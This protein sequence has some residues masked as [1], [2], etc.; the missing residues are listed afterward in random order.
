MKRLFLLMLST[1][2]KKIQKCST[3]LTMNSLSSTCII[4]MDSVKASLP[5]R[6]LNKW[7]EIL[8]SSSQDLLS[9]DLESMSNI[10]METDSHNGTTSS[11]PS[12]E[13]S[14]SKCTVFH[15]SVMTFVDSTT[16]LGLNSVQDGCNLDL[17]IHSLV[18]TT[19]TSPSHK[20]HTLSQLTSTF[21]PHQS[22]H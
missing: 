20:S 8:L 1:T 11:S 10:G 16:M 18:T 3:S 12:Q 13:S 17:S 22:R 7:V 19:E 6:L 14:T 9:S 4:S 2:T 15:L 5:T 21:L